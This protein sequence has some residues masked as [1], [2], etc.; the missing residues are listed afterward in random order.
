MAAALLEQARLDGNTAALLADLDALHS[1]EPESGA[2]R[3]CGTTFPCPTRCR[4]DRAQA[5][6]NTDGQPWR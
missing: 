5:E 1:V 2:C 6:R 3:S 4:L